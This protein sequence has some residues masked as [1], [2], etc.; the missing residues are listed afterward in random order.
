MPESKRE[1]LRGH[2]LL[3]QGTASESRHS[4]SNESQQTQ[5][6]AR[7]KSAKTWHTFLVE[8]D[9]N[10]MPLPGVLS[11]MILYQGPCSVQSTLQQGYLR[12]FDP[13]L[14]YFGQV[15]MTD[16]ARALRFFPKFLR[17]ETGN[18]E[19]FRAA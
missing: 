12:L 13:P 2:P 14:N 18:A 1:L 8:L 16:I 3:H 19:N 5:N 6:L 9:L 4:L 15:K 11:N 7:Q 10:I 17:I